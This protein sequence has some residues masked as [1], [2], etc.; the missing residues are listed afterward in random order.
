[1]DAKAMQVFS[2]DRRSF[3]RTFGGLA[4]G[5][6]AAGLVRAAISAPSSLLLKTSR[7]FAASEEPLIQPLELSTEDGVLS[8][9]LTAAPRRV[10]LGDFSFDG[11]L[12]N[13]KYIPPLLRVRLGDS[14]RIAFR[15]DLPDDPSNLH[16]HGMSFSRKGTAT[17]CLFTSFLASSSNM[18]CI[19]PGVDG[20]AR[21]SFG[22]TRTRMGLLKSRS[23]AECLVVLLSTVQT[24]FI[25]C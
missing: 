19:F 17:T 13:E 23:S 20:K 10:E 2:P 21:A 7:A 4:Q 16:Y 18:R 12:Y 11:F 22:I 8:T 9:T 3:L 1:M 14:L 6:A 15:N 25:R 5:I 24:S